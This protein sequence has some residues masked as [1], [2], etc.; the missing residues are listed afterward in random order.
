VTDHYRGESQNLTTAAEANVLKLR[1][2]LEIPTEAERSR[3]EQIKKDFNKRKLLGGAAE[4]SP[5][6]RVVAQMTQF[7]DGLDAI[8]TEIGRTGGE[9]AK[10]Q[11]LGETTIEQLTKTIEGLRWNAC[12]GGHPRDGVSFG[13]PCLRGSQRLF[14]EGGKVVIDRRYKRA[15]RPL[16]LV[17]RRS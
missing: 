15:S 1:E 6:A 3:W 10:P 7:T 4:S 13:F 5:V 16:P 17:H 2:M 14:P 8:R 12:R 11:T 9:F